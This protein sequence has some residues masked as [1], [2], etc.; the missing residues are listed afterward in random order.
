MIFDNLFDENNMAILYVLYTTA[1]LLLV[2]TYINSRY[3][4]FPKLKKEDENLVLY[5][6]KMAIMTIM[7]LIIFGICRRDILIIFSSIFFTFFIFFPTNSQ[8]STNKI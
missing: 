8:K 5:T 4:M 3:H 1:P 2:Y 7:L 6:K